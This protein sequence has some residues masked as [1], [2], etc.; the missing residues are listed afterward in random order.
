MWFRIKYF[1]ANSYVTKNL[2]LREYNS[3]YVRPNRTKEDL[4]CTLFKFSKNTNLYAD[5]RLNCLNVFDFYNVKQWEYENY[6]GY[7][8]NYEPKC[9]VPHLNA[10]LRFKINDT[11]QGIDNKIDVKFGRKDIYTFHRREIKN[12]SIGRHT[13]V[14]G[15]EHPTFSDFYELLHSASF[16]MFDKTIGK[17]IEVKNDQQL[18]SNKI[19]KCILMNVNSKNKKPNYIKETK[20][21]IELT[22]EN[23]YIWIIFLDLWFTKKYN[24]KK[25]QNN[26]S[27][28]NSS[29]S[30]SQS[31]TKSSTVVS[32][33]SI[34]PTTKSK[35]V[36]A[37]SMNMAKTMVNKNLNIN[38][39][40]ISLNKK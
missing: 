16:S 20:F 9:I 21:I 38:N 17:H 35:N 36:A 8:I 40:V 28:T 3:L 7:A 18:V 10:K 34:I 22:G 32:K 1:Q 19:Y 25:K 31:T 6:V 11:V 13:V 24:Q 30:S 27:S 14:G 23:S 33:I 29:M 12:S 15:F 5:D 4:T 39:K 2:H 37:K 26:S